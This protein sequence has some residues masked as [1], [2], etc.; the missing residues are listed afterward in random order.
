MSEITLKK[1]VRK[2]R[3]LGN[4]GM[5]RAPDSTWVLYQTLERLAPAFEA[6]CVT[7]KEQRTMVAGTEK[8]LEE[9]RAAG[10]L[11]TRWEVLPNCQPK[12]FS[13]CLHRDGVKFGRFYSVK[14]AEYVKAAME[15]AEAG[16]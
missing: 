7:L 14:D 5:F 15:K 16:T 10:L 6:V 8:I 9:L 4:T 1:A 11:G 2:V 3:E 13:V 12:P